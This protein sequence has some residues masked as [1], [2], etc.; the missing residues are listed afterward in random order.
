M[1]RRERDVLEPASRSV[2]HEEGRPTTTAVADRKITRKKGNGI[3]GSAFL[4]R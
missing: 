1:S 4:C 3:V 2:A